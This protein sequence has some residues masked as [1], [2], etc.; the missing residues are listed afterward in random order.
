[1]ADMICVL[2]PLQELSRKKNVRLYMCFIDVAKN[3]DPIERLA[4]GVL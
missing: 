3:Y 2:L 4:C 1:M